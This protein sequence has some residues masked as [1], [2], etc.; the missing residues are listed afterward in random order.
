[1]RVFLR[2]CAASAVS[3]FLSVHAA[4]AQAYIAPS[5]GVLLGNESGQGRATFGAGF[6]WLAP[7]EPIGVELD[8]VYAPSFFGNAGPLGD[9]SVTTVMADVIIAGGD[10]GR[11]GYRGR[12][13][14]IR[15]YVSGGLGVMH[16][17]TTAGPRRVGNDDLGA[18][19][20]GGVFGLGRRGIGV[21]G[22]VRY[23]RNLV[24]AAGSGDADFGAFHFWRASLG[25]VIG[26]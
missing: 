20:G 19:I 16:E 8:L 26:F 10:S 23:F 12:G 14:W 5:L 13:P 4:R 2:V 6:G 17:V 3:F 21:R 11:Y 7:R 1:M 22:D 24:N 18:N 25:L 9:N 15:P